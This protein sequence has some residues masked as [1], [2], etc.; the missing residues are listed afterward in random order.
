MDLSEE[1]ESY[2]MQPQ[3]PL[4]QQQVMEDLRLLQGRMRE[5]QKWA[6]SAAD[7][8]HEDKIRIRTL[9]Q[10]LETA[11]TSQG[12]KSQLEP[13][14]LGGMEI[15]A[16]NSHD[17]S[18]SAPSRIPAGTEISATDSQDSSSSAPS[19]Y[20][21]SRLNAIRKSR[22]AQEAA[23]RKRF[24]HS[25]KHDQS[26]TIAHQQ[27]IE[28]LTKNIKELEEEMKKLQAEKVQTRDESLGIV[29][30]LKYLTLSNEA[31]RKRFQVEL[32]KKDKTIAELEAESKEFEQII[33]ESYKERENLQT[34]LHRSSQ[35]I[36]SLASQVK[37]ISLTNKRI[38]ERDKDLLAQLSDF[39]RREEV[40]QGKVRDLQIGTAQ[41]HLEDLE[42]S[43]AVIRQLESIVNDLQKDGEEDILEREALLDRESDWKE[44]VTILE[45]ENTQLES[46]LQLAEKNLSEQVSKEKS[47]LWSKKIELFLEQN[48]KK[49]LGDLLE[50]QENEILRISS[51]LEDVKKSQQPKILMEETRNGNTAIELMK[52]KRS[53]Q[54]LHSIIGDLQEEAQDEQNKVEGFL[55]RDKE[56]EEE[57]VS[58]RNEIGMMKLSEQDASELIREDGQEDWEER[59]D[60]TRVNLEPQIEQSE[61]NLEELI[62]SDELYVAPEMFIKEKEHLSPSGL[63]NIADS[64]QWISEILLL[65]SEIRWLKKALQINTAQPQ[66]PVVALNE[67]IECDYA[68]E[69]NCSDDEALKEGNDDSSLRQISDINNKSRQRRTL[70]KDI[71]VLRQDLS[72]LTV[73]LQKSHILFESHSNDVVVSRRHSN[74]SFELEEINHSED[75]LS[76]DSGFEE[77]INL[78][79]TEVGRMYQRRN[80]EHVAYGDLPSS[81][82][83]LRNE[84]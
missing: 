8:T 55:S 26:G 84:M 69:D 68:F 43:H 48:G 56:Y 13:Q 40:L 35:N 73:A 20:T 52:S 50:L 11:K 66:E 39:K 47:A 60:H 30:K 81:S 1:K 18:S 58:L 64:D 44:Q 63:S 29:Q 65:R 82:D 71:V 49:Q 38:E 36:Q 2:D 31:D 27:R 77:E 4:T 21:T 3:Q 80:M 79:R 32:N 41:T 10:Q 17:S 76:I 70:S 24:V 14:A 9:E 23:F 45:E 33:E 12:A 83:T 62:Q 74:D 57:I 16:S 67:S 28:E 15:S 37:I 61:N 59:E 72:Q 75:D 46:S 34:A 5:M 78:L 6:K 42:E 51:E 22:E 25:T 53:I 54:Q 19:K 7:Q